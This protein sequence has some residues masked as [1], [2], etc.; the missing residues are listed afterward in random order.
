DRG[1]VDRSERPADGASVAFLSRS[2]DYLTSSFDRR[3][4]TRFH[5]PSSRRPRRRHPTTGG[6]D[7]G[8][9]LGDASTTTTVP[10]VHMRTTLVK[11][12]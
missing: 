3:H 12:R 6:G 7:P 9:D 4:V 2:G 5:G 8:D 10:T 11:A 1:A